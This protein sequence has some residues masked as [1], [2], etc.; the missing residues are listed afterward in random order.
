MTLIQYISK[1]T[2]EFKDSRVVKKTENLLKKNCR[3]KNNK[4]MVF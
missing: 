3:E 4:N 1:I 2:K